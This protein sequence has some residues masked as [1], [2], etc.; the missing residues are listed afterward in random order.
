MNDSDIGD[1]IMAK[2]WMV[3]DVSPLKLMNMEWPEKDRSRMYEFYPDEELAK[4]ALLNPGP[5]DLLHG[6]SYGKNDSHI[7][8]PS[9]KVLIEIETSPAKTA[10]FIQ[11]TINLYGTV[12][13]VRAT[14]EGCTPTTCTYYVN[15]DLLHKDRA[16][17]TE[18]LGP[19]GFTHDVLH[20]IYAREHSL[21]AAQAAIDRTPYTRAIAISIVSPAEREAVYQ[22]YSPA[23]FV[24]R[25]SDSEI[26]AYAQHY[27]ERMST[28]L[29]MDSAMAIPQIAQK[30][31]YH[32][33]NQPEEFP[34]GVRCARGMQQAMMEIIGTTFIR[35]RNETLMMCHDIL[36][37]TRT[38][39]SR[40]WE[41]A[42]NDIQDI[43]KK[44]REDEE[45][46]MDEDVLEE[47]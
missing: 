35:D 17:I 13:V 47:P 10:E 5:K 36:S 16:Q 3:A 29:P 19:S 37:Q 12:P 26:D 39:E 45:L 38:D 14:L 44:Y 31:E 20:T 34:L 6:K 2:Y 40:S 24:R 30:F 46:L 33:G 8:Y 7:E 43:L 4:A 23:G 42:W 9:V 11:N 22:V 25:G 28:K 27:F 32:F 15:P 41:E 1:I 21:K 18:K